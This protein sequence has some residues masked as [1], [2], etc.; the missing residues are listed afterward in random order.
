MEIA[1]G[2]L[3]ILLLLLPGI[4]FR[5][6]FFSE[7]FS[8][9]YTIKD[10]FQ[11]FTNTLF[12]S[13]FFYVL[14]LPIIYFL[15]EYYY[16]F[17][18]IL[19]LLS[20]QEDLIKHSINRIDY[21]KFEIV[22]FQ[23]LINVIAFF[24]G[25][26]IKGIIVKNSYDARSKFLRYKNIWHYLL[27]A[28]FILFE[29]SQIELNDHDVTD[30]DITFIDAL[31]VVGDQNFIYTGILVDYELSSEGSLDL[32]YIKDAQRKLINNENS[33]LKD[34]NGNIIILKYENIVN[35]NLSFI[36]INELENDQVEFILI[37]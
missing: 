8:N 24:V 5:K 4:S 33:D 19:G 31:L 6:G 2:G 30:V 34:I 16:D 17:N 25:Y 3:I 36:E 13:L 11:L 35:L 27:S 12:P 20:N 37:S 9:Q 26:L 14:F 32:L 29:R 22:I 1:L 28:K 15:W 18:V 10:F 21:F 23:F 7:E